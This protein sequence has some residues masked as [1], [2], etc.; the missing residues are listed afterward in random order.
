M[1][2]RHRPAVIRSALRPM[3]LL[4]LL[5]WTSWATIKGAVT[6]ILMMQVRGHKSFVY[7]L[8]NQGVRWDRWARTMPSPCFSS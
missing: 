3:V 7:I 1:C 6:A 8:E 4:Q 5:F 2:W